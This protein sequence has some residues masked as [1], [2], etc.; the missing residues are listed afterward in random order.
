MGQSILSDRKIP[1]R[2]GDQIGALARR[3]RDDDDAVTDERESG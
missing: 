1:F 2:N 3:A